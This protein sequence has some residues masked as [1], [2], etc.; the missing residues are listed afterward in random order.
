[1]QRF[2]KGDFLRADHLIEAVLEARLK[3]DKAARGIAGESDK[4]DGAGKKKKKGPK[5]SDIRAMKLED[6]VVSE[7]KEVLAKV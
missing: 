4:A 7:Y 1:M 2:E 3:G 5:V 6:S